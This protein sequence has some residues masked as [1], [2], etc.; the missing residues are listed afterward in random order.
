MQIVDAQ[1]HLWRSGLPVNAAHRQVTEFST[2]EAVAMMDEGGVNAAVI[3]PPSWDPGAVDLAFEAVKNHPG[4]FAIMGE[5]PLDESIA[6]EQ[7]AT[8]RNQPGMLGLRYIFYHDA[9]QQRLENNG[10]DW[11]W[12]A[13]S[14]AHVPVSVLVPHSLPQLGEIANR[15]PDLRLTIDHLGGMGGFTTKKDAAAMTHFPELIKLAKYPNIAVKATGAPGYCSEDYPFTPIHTY[16]EQIYDAFGPNRMF[17]GTDITKMPVPW[18]QCIELF[19]QELPWLRDEDKPL[20][21]GQALCDW[22]GW[23]RSSQVNPTSV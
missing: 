9:E 4:R 7:I 5:L 1:I 20:V 8:W 3:N 16:L 14:D 2:E 15:F 6:G 12:R 22:W 23:D 18:K 10:L 13:A 17:W 19:T 21:M 11:L